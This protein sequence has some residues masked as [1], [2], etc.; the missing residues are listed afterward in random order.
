[1]KNKIIFKKSSILSVI[2][3]IIIMLLFNILFYI[4]MPD[5]LP[6][7][8]DINGTVDKYA[9]KTAAFL[10]LPLGLTLLD[11]LV[12]FMLDND[13]RNRNQ[14]NFI[15]TI[16]KVI[17]PILLFFIYTATV[18]T[19]K[20]VPFDM[21]ISIS[22]LMGVLLILIGNYLPKAK[23][24]YTVGIK[25]PWTLSNDEIWNKTHR[26]GGI[27]FMISGILM[28]VAGIL[29]IEILFVI[30]I[31]TAAILPNAYSFYLY[32]KGVR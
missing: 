24:S 5:L 12:V 26:F 1:M 14:K 23:R 27:C 29:K 18:M 7:H 4:E 21:S 20:K 32:S 10:L 3:C 13:P 19:V 9:S 11:I 28:I 17:M 25:N 30:L 15:M 8:W 22:A 2:S 16:G 6:I 31:F